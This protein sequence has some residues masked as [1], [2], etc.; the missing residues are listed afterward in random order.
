VVE[1]ELTVLAG[2]VQYLAV[3]AA[4]VEVAAA[5]L[6]DFQELLIQEVA[7]AAEDILIMLPEL[8]APE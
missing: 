3:L 8:V 4:A 5:P 6:A 1:V 2:L 7:A